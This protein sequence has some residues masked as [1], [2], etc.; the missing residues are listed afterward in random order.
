MAISIAAWHARSRFR[1]IASW[2]VKFASRE[3]SPAYSSATRRS[4][5]SMMAALFRQTSSTARLPVR[6]DDGPALLA[7]PRVVGQ[8]AHFE[9]VDGSA[10]ADVERCA[11]RH[12]L[13]A[14]HKLAPRVQHGKLD[15][16]PGDELEVSAEREER[17]GLHPRLPRD[18]KRQVEVA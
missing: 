15:R 14:V 13:L 12:D 18:E 9:V 2:W 5:R 7:K 8:H 16:A 11:V 3:G 10:V 6:V 1:T 17:Q 4:E